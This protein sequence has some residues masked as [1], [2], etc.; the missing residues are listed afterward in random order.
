MPSPVPAGGVD[1]A[2]QPARRRPSGRLRL[3]LAGGSIVAALLV[4][5]IGLRLFWSP[6]S[7]Q[8]HRLFE[9]H[10]F[11]G[12]APRPGIE[13]VHV[14]PEYRHTAHNSVQGLR[15]GT[16][17]NRRKL[18]GCRA[19][20]LF[21]GDSFTYGLGSPGAATFVEVFNQARRD[22]EVVNSGANGYSTRECL[23]VLDHLGAAL[24]P[25]VTVY[26]FF[27]NDLD[28]NL[29]RR[30]PDYDIG[31]DGLVFRRDRPRPTTDPL[32]L[33]PAGVLET[34]SPWRRFYVSDLIKEGMKGFRYNLLGVKQRQVH[35]DELKA[36]A[37]RKT[38][39]LL[40]LMHLR[41]QEIGTRLVV[42]CLPD[43]NQVN[44]EAVIKNIEPLNFEVQAELEAVCEKQQIDYV[45]LLPGMKQRWQASGDD[46][47]YYED[48]HLTP[49]G[50]A[51][52]AELLG[53]ALSPYLPK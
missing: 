36:E 34:N 23:A 49:K 21:L 7:I 39:G 10:E 29:S 18:P 1:R 20:V 42:V 13:G 52:V 45:D 53:A 24:V 43:H 11:Y 15:G 33:R 19:R 50:N 31:E 48:R 28:D 9:P 46:F 37:W 6:W 38:E 14:T 3:V 2:A 40:R 17:F 35:T 12:W 30:T 25:D 44:P 32:A 41:A 22:V 47:Y 27:W 8:S 5:E 4:A 16:V 26:M 51:A